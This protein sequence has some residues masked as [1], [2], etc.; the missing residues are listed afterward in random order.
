MTQQHVDR[1]FRI[2]GILDAKNRKIRLLGRKR[3]K[4]KQTKAMDT[5]QRGVPRTGS[6][7]PSIRGSTPARPMAN[8]EREKIKK[9]A[10]KDLSKDTVAAP[11]M[12]GIARLPIERRAAST[13]G[14]S[15]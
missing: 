3:P 5:A 12:S 9:D 2:V 6:L 10:F 11:S 14:A 4:H 13:N 8:R 7:V 1:Y 15:D